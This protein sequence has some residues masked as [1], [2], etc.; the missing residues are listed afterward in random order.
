[1]GRRTKQQFR[2]AKVEASSSSCR[3]SVLPRSSITGQ[4][5]PHRRS[6]FRPSRS[7]AIVAL[8][9]TLVASVRHHRR[10]SAL[11]KTLGFT[12]RQLAATTAWQA[13]TTAA[14]GTIVGVPIGIILGRWLW[15]LFAHS[16]NAVPDPTVPTI[17]ITLVAIGALVLTNVIALF[18]GL[19]A[20][21]TRV[22]LLLRAE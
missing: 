15:I 1:M 11:L 3:C 18:P 4:W 7:A 22:A 13:S 17:S 19:I 20:A 6:S 10:E 2:T 14:I 12:K 9:L 16:I 21:R 5:A 8:G